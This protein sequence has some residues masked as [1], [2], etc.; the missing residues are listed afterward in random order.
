MK[1]ENIIIGFYKWRV[2]HI[3]NRNFILLLSIIIGFLSGIA[4]VVIKNSVHFIQHSLIGRFSETVENYLFIAYPAIGILL[5][6]IFIKFFLKQPIGDGVPNVLYSISKSNGLMKPHNIYS[7][8]IASALT[9][10]FGGSVGLEGPTVATGAAI[11]SNVGRVLRLNYKQIVSLLGFASAGAMAA[12]FQAPIA[13]IVFALEVIMLDLT[14][15]SLIPLLTASAVAAMTSYFFLGQ[16]VLYPVEVIEAFQLGDVLYYIILGVTTGLISVYFI[17]TIDFAGK[18]FEKI[19]G[20]VLRL[21]IGGSALGLLVF[22]FPALYGEG[23]SSINSSLGGDFDYIFDKSLFF[24]FKGNF[25]F[26]IMLLMAIIVLKV[27]ASAAT[28]GSG[29]IGGIFAPTLFTGTHIGLLF[30]LSINHFGIGD[31]SVSNFALVGMAGMISGVIR[32]PLTAIFLIAE[33][34]GGYALI[35][36]LMIVSTISFATSRIFEPDSVYTKQLSKKIDIIT[37]HKD[38][39]VLSLMKIDSLIETN[40]STIHPDATL[41]KLVDVIEN[42]TRNIFPVVDNDNNFVGLIFL[43]RVRHIMFKPEVYD[44][45]L[46]RNLMFVPTTIVNYTDRMEEVAHKFQH[47]GKYNLVVLNDGKY[48][49]FVSRANVFSKYREMLK[50]FSEH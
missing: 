9:V 12:I 24:D 3:T 11:G 44:E 26:T 17:R 47:S 7:S 14:L 2:K 40:F 8:V 48:M 30:A 5:V 19:K 46:V 10:G 1:I 41:R 49:G 38:K 25:S 16:N 27:V 33:I 21:L 20:W 35:M 43:D 36:P 23:Y 18:F 4:A 42:S 29:G 50:E 34:T 13:A 39:A 45:V 15:S 31:I 28:F 6:M 37:H 22:L 32:G